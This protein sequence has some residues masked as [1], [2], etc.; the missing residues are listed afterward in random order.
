MSERIENS[1]IILDKNESHNVTLKSYVYDNVDMIAGELFFSVPQERNTHIIMLANRFNSNSV[2]ENGPFPGWWLQIVGNQLSLGF[3]NGQTWL[4]VKASNYIVDDKLH[5]V[6]FSINNNT[7]IA[8]LYL[9]GIHHSIN[10]INFKYPGNVVTVGALNQRKEFMFPGYLSNISLGS[11]INVDNLKK[12]ISDHT[13]QTENI[14]LD[15]MYYMLD[16][17]ENN[18]NNLDNDI[19]SL[20]DIRN[21]IESWKYRGLAID[22]Q[23]LDNQIDSFTD[24]KNDFMKSTQEAVEVIKIVD[25]QI[26]PNNEPENNDNNIFSKYRY[27]INNLN[28]D[29]KIL[30]NIVS[31]LSE[32]TDIGVKL[33]SAITTIDEQKEIIK[34]ILLNTE[35]DLYERNNYLSTLTE[36]VS[37]DDN[38]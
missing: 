26:K 36:I 8:E 25:E 24:N 6:V 9:D 23:L 3:G 17:I 22:T 20:N 1:I 15:E 35:K 16:N 33:G 29:V 5:H 18:M 34:N 14:V 30:D 31:E 13:K 27:H 7:K 19:K 21:K 28:N 4:S 10:N 38:L 12:F 2:E 37:I 32:F 11:S